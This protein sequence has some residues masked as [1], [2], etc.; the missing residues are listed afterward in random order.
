MGHGKGRR[1]A[2]LGEIRPAASS[3]TPP[4]DGQEG[5]CPAGHGENPPGFTLYGC[6]HR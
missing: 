6:P 3:A 1:R 4:S 5:D 2:V